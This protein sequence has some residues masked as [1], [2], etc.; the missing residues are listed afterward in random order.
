MSA[1]KPT[2]VRFTT[3]VDVRLTRV[4]QRLGISKSDAVRIMVADELDRLEWQ[5]A[6][7]QRAADARRNR[8]SLPTI[9]EIAAQYDVDLGDPDPAL[10]DDVS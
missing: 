9:Q 1:I 6:I 5:A 2:S 8:G 7:R 4:A 10:L 3:D